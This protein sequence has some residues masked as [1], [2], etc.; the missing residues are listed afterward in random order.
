M[1]LW[2]QM[3]VP[4]LLLIM[5]IVALLHATPA[6]LGNVPERD[7]GVFLYIG[8]A[9]L[10]GQIPYRDVWDHKPPLIYFIN[11]LGLMLNSNSFWGVWI[12]EIIFLAL[13]L[14]AGFVVLQPVCS[15]W[16][17]LLCVGLVVAQLPYMMWGG[18]LTEFYALAFQFG[19]MWIYMTRRS[20]LGL[21]A[22]GVLGGL[23]FLL[24]QN[25]VGLWL[26]TGLLLAWRATQEGRWQKILAQ[27]G[28]LGLG[29]AIPIGLVSIWFALHD[30]L[31]DFWQ[32]AFVY[33]FAYVGSGGGWYNRFISLKT[34]LAIG[35]YPLLPF[36][37]I[38]SFITTRHRP[39]GSELA[40]L[41][42]I[43]LPIELLLA[44]L[45]GKDHAHY[46]ITWLPV[47]AVLLA[48]TLGKFWKMPKVQHIMARPVI[49]HG[50]FT[51]A[52]YFG[53]MIAAGVATW[54][55]LFTIT[56]VIL[57]TNTDSAPRTHL[58]RTAAALLVEQTQSDDKLLVWGAEPYLHIFSKRAAISRY[59]YQYSLTRQGF[60]DGAIVREFAQDLQV[61]R[62][63]V[64]IDTRNP[65]LPP[66]ESRLRVDW[67]FPI[68][69]AP[70]PELETI[71]TWIAQ[72][73]ELVECI[74]DQ[75]TWCI[76]RFRQ[77]P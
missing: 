31:L 72:H 8:Q 63:S 37:W 73:Y 77:A 75:E 13:T 46:Y 6:A 30:A 57:A 47:W 59:V 49:K 69:Y 2:R 28:V 12:L 76:Y 51:I 36:L 19:A 33:N 54:L 38:A 58:Y 61:A 43:L 4:I 60:A 34:G 16:L 35:L 74:E 3:A 64:I 52:S 1:K 11:A 22:I 32:A 48:V 66:L 18:N 39:D 68:G 29:A 17:A 20:W 55:G 5:S 65:A 23:T 70:I 42:L 41:G 7:S 45:S 71:T 67:E 26:A 50:R 10:D 53:V 21:F 25:L 62:P 44:T 14:W 15:N 24:R 40:E 9:L 27:L 56:F